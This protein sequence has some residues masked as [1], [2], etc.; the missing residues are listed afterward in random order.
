MSTTLARPIRV[1]CFRLAWAAA[2]GCCVAGCGGGGS[3]EQNTPGALAQATQMP[4]LYAVARVDAEPAGAHC[5]D[6][7]SRISAGVDANR[8]GLLDPPEVETTQ[9]VCNGARGPGGSVG[10]AGPAGVAGVAGTTGAMGATGQAGLAGLVRLDSEPAGTHCAAG[11]SRVSVGGD[12]N[13]DGRLDPSEVTS[14]AYICNGTGGTNGINGTNGTDGFTGLVALMAEPAGAHCAYGGTRVASGVDTDR[15]GVLGPA[16]VMATSYLCAGPP[17]GVAW[18][19]VTGTAQA[20][21]PNTG[22]LAESAAEVTVTLPPS[23]A[24]GDIVRVTGVG[25]GGWK[26]GQNAG[27]FVATA[28]LPG[29]VGPGEQWAARDVRRGWSSVASSSDGTHLVASEIGGHLYTSTDGGASWTPRDAIRNWWSVASSADGSRLIASVTND[30]L[31]LSV[32]YGV[33]W[34]PAE[35]AR[36][37][38]GVASSAD[39]TRLAAVANAD[40]I[41]TSADAGASW[42]PQGPTANW[43]SAAMSADGVH[44]FAAAEGQQMYSTADGG[45]TWTW[46]GPTIAWNSVAASADGRRVVA[47]AWQEQIYTSSDYGVSW[48]ANASAHQWL[49]LA[50]SADGN[51]LIAADYDGSLYTSSDAGATWRQ[52]Q[53]AAYPWSGAASSGDGSRLLAVNYAGPIFLSVGTLQ[54]TV[55]SAGSLSGGRGASVELQYLGAGEF[56]VLSHNDPAGGFTVR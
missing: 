42:Q 15:N 51:R 1:D 30:T 41:Y 50:S 7:G 26:I 52:Q 20:A 10:S 18:V 37:W 3:S 4:P 22:Y 2:F 8:N 40:Q 48:R 24:V 35:T 46:S 5:A 55:G 36:N 21:Q 47:A 13:A 6:G 31:Y 39:G 9:Y 11:G 14:T 44:V 45:A 29:N 25:S 54:T 33:T 19:D 49:A 17:G 27:Q 23:L 53:A 34:S 56:T 38:R 28:G 43:R 16:E 32:D 12:S